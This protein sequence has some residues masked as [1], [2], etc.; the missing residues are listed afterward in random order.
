MNRVIVCGSRTWED[1]GAIRARLLLLDPRTTI[2]VGGA[3]GADKLAEQAAYELGFLV[4]IHE[5]Q[6]NT[7][8]RRA[9]YVRNSE[10]AAAGA[11]LVIA[12]WD[13]HSKG[14]A[15]M[16]DQAAFYGIPYEVIKAD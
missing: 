2:V 1:V 3:P 9:G 12:F 16:L 11:S 14:T 10:M 6:W 13:G 8:G 15:N 5:A 7:Y 4:E